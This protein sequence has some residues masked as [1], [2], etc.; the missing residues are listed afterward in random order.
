MKGKKRQD[1]I[2]N[3]INKLHVSAKEVLRRQNETLLLATVDQKL[4]AWTN[5]G[6]KDILFKAAADVHK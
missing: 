6:D 4:S 2:L 3:D 5:R 1:N